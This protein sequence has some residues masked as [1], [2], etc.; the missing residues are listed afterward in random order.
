MPNSRLNTPIVPGDLLL[1]IQMQG[2]DIDPS[3]TN[4]YG[5]GQGDGGTGGGH[6]ADVLR[7]NGTQIFVAG[8]LIQPVTDLRPADLVIKFAYLLFGILSHVD[9]SAMLLSSFVF[10]ESK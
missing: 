7:R 5:D 1:V 6:A 3:N 10:P 2:A 4:R 9:L 8:V